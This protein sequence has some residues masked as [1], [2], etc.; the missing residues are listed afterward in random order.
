MW[1]ISGSFSQTCD[2]IVF[3]QRVKVGLGS[4]SNF[5]SLFVLVLVRVLVTTLRII[6]FWPR[7]TRTV[8]SI[9]DF[10][11]LGFFLVFFVLFVVTWFAFKIIRCNFK[12]ETSDNSLPMSD[13]QPDVDDIFTWVDILI[14]I[15]KTR[16]R[17]STLWSLAY[18][19]Y[20]SD[21]N[22]GIICICICNKYYFYFL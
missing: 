22:L 2:Q 10:F 7:S 15:Q 5:A 11:S 12:K 4:I 3:E 1:L 21:I 20:F 18:V 8:I 16:I 17:W 9:V 19:L 13:E 6:F 14:K